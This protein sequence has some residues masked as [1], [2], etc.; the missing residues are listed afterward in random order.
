MQIFKFLAGK[1]SNVSHAVLFNFTKSPLI[2]VSKKLHVL[3]AL[4]CAAE[5]R[6]AAGADAAAVVAVLARLLE[7]H[8]A[9]VV[10]GRLVD[11]RTTVRTQVPKTS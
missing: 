6:P 1:K 9:L 4:Y 3:L 7:A 2:K 8:R 10:V 11:L 5:E